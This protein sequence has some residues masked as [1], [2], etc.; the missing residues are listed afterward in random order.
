MDSHRVPQSSL[1]PSPN[2]SGQ[3]LRV[4]APPS[5]WKMATEFCQWSHTSSTPTRLYPLEA[6]N[7]LVRSDE[8]IDLILI[9]ATVPYDELKA[10]IGRVS[11]MHTAAKINLRLW[12]IDGSYPPEDL[13][14][15]YDDKR[16]RAL[17]LLLGGV[18]LTVALREG[19]QA[20]PRGD[21]HLFAAP[22]L[23]ILEQESRAVSNPGGLHAFTWSELKERTNEIERLSRWA[24][25][26]FILGLIT[27]ISTLLALDGDGQQSFVISLFVLAQLALGTGVIG[28]LWSFF[29]HRGIR[30]RVFLFWIDPTLR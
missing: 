15:L 25:V 16:I 23:T 30:Q 24:R 4:L 3:A 28:T 2:Q 14:S 19:Q 26:P 6:L 11:L 22:A 20:P 18:T 21:H 1:G 13:Q 7:E 5:L 10:M 12:C 27:S 29:E 8:Y 17:S 9:S